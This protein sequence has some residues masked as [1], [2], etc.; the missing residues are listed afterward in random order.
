MQGNYD[1][2]ASRRSQD[3]ILLME[4]YVLKMEFYL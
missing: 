1:P 3:G 2:L 4:F